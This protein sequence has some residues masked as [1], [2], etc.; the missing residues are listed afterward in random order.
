[1]S[2]YCSCESP[3]LSEGY[4]VGVT[5]ALKTADYC[6]TCGKLWIGSEVADRGKMDYA[7]AMKEPVFSY[8]LDSKAWMVSS[9]HGVVGEPVRWEKE[10][11]LTQVEDGLHMLV[12]DNVIVARRQWT[13][14]W[15]SNGRRMYV[16]DIFEVKGHQGVMLRYHIAGLNA[17]S[18]LKE[19]EGNAK[20]IGN[21]YMYPELMK[22]IIRSV[23]G[24]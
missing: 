1:M 18:N 24:A 2:M 16:G 19:W 10:L 17:Y 20:A 13:G 22:T 7:Q 14:T 8:V 23:G 12:Q 6:D 4:A 21:E 15:Y 9:G 3:E 11:T 5:G